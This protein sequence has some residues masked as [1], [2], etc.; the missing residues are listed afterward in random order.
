[1]KQTHSVVKRPLIT[2]KSMLLAQ[3]GWYS[4]VVSKISRKETIAKEISRLYDVKVVEITTARRVGKVRRTGRKMK[5]IKRPDWKK[6][7]VRLEK[8]QRIP[9]FEAGQENAKV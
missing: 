7:M 9:V 3:K 5:Q 2:E 4:F 6:A 1:M 8:G